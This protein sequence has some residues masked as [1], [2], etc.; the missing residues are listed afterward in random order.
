MN[1]QMLGTIHQVLSNLG[2]GF[3][4]EHR[5]VALRLGE[6]ALNDNFYLQFL[7]GQ[8]AINQG[9]ELELICLSTNAFIPL[10]RFIG[11]T[12]VVEQRDQ[13]G[14]THII[15]GIITQAASG[16]S[17][18][19]FAIYKLTLQDSLSGLLPKRRN[20][21]VFMQQSVLDITQTLL[22]EWQQKSALFA[23]SLGLDLSKLTKPYDVLPFTMQSQESDF[24][25]LTRLW[26]RVGINWMID[27]VGTQQVLALLDDVKIL[28]Q[29]SAPVLHFHHADHKTNQDSI[30][31]LTAQRNLKNSH[32]HLQ[33]W[34]PQHGS[35]DEQASVNHAQQSETYASASLNLEQAYYIGDEALGDLDGKDQ[36][37][38]PSSQQL[39]RL[40]ELLI[41]RH[42]LETKSFNAT[43]SIRAVKVGHWFKLSGHPQLDQ[44][45][46]SQ[47]EFL[48]TQLSFYAKNNLP[49]DISEQVISLVHQSQ[50]ACDALHQQQPHQTYL[51]LIQRD[52]VIVP[53]YDPWLHMAKAS[54]M[55]ARVVGAEG[56]TIH[57]DAWGRIK[58]RFLFTRPDDHAHRGGAGSSDTDTDSAWV[59]VLTPWAGDNS[60]NNYGVRFL[61]R[62]GELVVIDFLDGNADQPMIVGRIHEGSRLPTQFDHQGTLPDTRALS[63]IKSQEV[64]GS[65]FN[66]LRFDDTTAQISAQLQSSHAASQLNLGHLSHPKSADTSNTRGE[67]FE[68]R[69]DQ[70]GAIR[71][72]KGLL[73]STHKQDQAKASHLDAIETKNQLDSTLNGIT[74]LSDMAKKQNT[75]PLEVLE[76]IKGFIDNLQQDNPQQ[77]A[78]FKSA[79]ML[80][81]SPE[82]IGLSSQA[83]IHVSAD[84]HISHSATNS[85]NLSTQNSLVAQA[86][87]KISLF[88]AQKG[89]SA[90]AAK[91]KIAL[92][93]QND[94]IEAIARKV[95]QIIS[96][97]DRI[98]IT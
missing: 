50:W 30:N 10:K 86:Q 77:A 61:P 16:Q 82:S 51:T 37:T 15:N 83:D 36:S 70:L 59:N 47:R 35:V 60:E 96:T 57:V 28:A 97:E 49:K 39:V 55:R 65:G 26:R 33:R 94:G 5:V 93:A 66:Q 25:F 11:Q 54:P 68:L 19:G 90:F 23:K 69:T 71:A 42:I 48:I 98:E 74:A 40:G 92:Q 79:I 6:A 63:G 53:F 64:N 81:T 4:A 84:G 12:A 56:E 88:A 31:I 80:L 43:G 22:A 67:G 62:V 41:Q 52:V 8:A 95:I 27:S 34:S 87:Q 32:A 21:R 73:L 17:D 20:S 75:D 1:Q 9:F 76:N 78:V 29:N 3:N 14:Q 46:A 72:G 45:P 91:G 7:S 24:D 58:V 2:I 38:Q 85:I 13:Q 18:A 44:K 89:I